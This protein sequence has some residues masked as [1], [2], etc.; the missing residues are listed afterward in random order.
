[1][2][3]IGTASGDVTAA[4]RHVVLLAAH[5]SSTDVEARARVEAHAARVATLVP[6]AEVRVGFAR[7]APSVATAIAQLTEGTDHERVTVTVVPFMT[8]AGHYATNVLPELLH[9]ATD[10]ARV[11]LLFT[12]PVGAHPRLARVLHRRALR[13]A[14]LSGW[15]PGDTA[16]VLVGHGTR[17]HPASRDTA[18]AHVRR[19]RAHGWL[20]VDAAFIDD[21]PTISEVLSRAT[22]ARLLVVPFLV[23]G[24]S[25]A[26]VD[27][28]EALGARLD[29]TDEARL[30]QST[31]RD[32]LLDEPV[33]RDDELADLAADLAIRAFGRAHSAWRSRELKPSRTRVHAVSLV[34][35]GPGAPDLITVRG[36][37]A[38]KRADVVLHD[39]LID[40][41]ILAIARPE[42][43]LIDVGKWPET[44]QDV[45]EEI[46][47]SLVTSARAGHRVVRLKGG[48]PMVFGR[49]AEELEACHAAGIPVRVVPGITSALAA[50]AAAGIPVTSRSVSRS[51]AIVTAATATDRA[52]LL[53]QVAQV[54]AADTIVV[55]MGHKRIADVCATLRAHGRDEHTLVACIE[56]AELPGQRV[57]RGTLATMPDVASDAALSSPMVMVIGPTA[58]DGQ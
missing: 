13:R 32:I 8:A 7:G 39:R 57:L 5:G 58:H 6:H 42:A 4:V 15:S 12:K 52:R 29:A 3:P 2:T 38:L 51:V 18:F 46:N 55:L 28:P 14:A 24:A 31:V 23:G 35:A 48:D 27:I 40:P 26:A 19:L 10:P 11:R 30:V 56:R 25:H 17:R 1:M 37:R 20:S 34:G 54:A 41:A 22:A 47:A 45:Q 16:L 9:N 50:P 43:Q 44:P 53:P 33:G 49:G 36:Q 21:D